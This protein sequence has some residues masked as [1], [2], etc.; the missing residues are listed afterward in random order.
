MEEKEV[1]RLL[2]RHGSMAGLIDHAQGDRKRFLRRYHPPELNGVKQTLA[3]SSI[4]DPEGPED[5]F[6]PFAK[7]GLFRKG[8]RLSR[9][10]D[11][12]R[13]YRGK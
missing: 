8:S 11:K 7:G 4:L 6:E 1:G 5:M 10:R 13:R 12:V 2:A 9:F 3:Q